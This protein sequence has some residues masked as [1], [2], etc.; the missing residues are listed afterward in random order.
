MDDVDTV[1]VATIT[2]LTRNPSLVIGLTFMG[3]RWEV[4]AVEDLDVW[5]EADLVVVDVGSTTEGL[6]RIRSLP[7]RTGSTGTALVIGDEDAA[8]SE[9]EH[10]LLR[11]FTV[12]ELTGYI[13]VLL[14][15]EPVP[16]ARPSDGGEPLHE[17]AV[18]V[19]GDRPKGPFPQE[20]E[21]LGARTT[22]R[23]WLDRLGS[24][25]ADRSAGAEEAVWTA[26]PPRDAVFGDTDQY[27]H[28]EGA[29]T[30]G[31][32]DLVIDLLSSEE[33]DADDGMPRDRADA[34][35]HSVDRPAGEQ[36]P[37]ADARASERQPP[38]ELRV[39]ADTPAPSGAVRRA[40]SRFTS[41]DQ[42]AHTPEA[43]MRRRLAAVITAGS[44]LESL[45]RDLPLLRSLKRVASL[46][47]EEVQE[48]LE[49]DT[50]A[51]LT[52]RA[53]GYYILASVGLSNVERRLVA[54]LDQPMLAEVDSTGGGLLIDPIDAAQAAVAGIGGAHT[55]SFMA[56]SI[57]A[58]CGRFGLLVAGRD[59]PLTEQDLD[60]LVS[61]AREAAPGIAVAQLLR[62][63]GALV[64][65]RTDEQ[66]RAE[67]VRGGDLGV[68]LTIDR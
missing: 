48:V 54:P 12:D 24:R 60:V 31:D 27:P 3:R 6:S 37:R 34:G 52:R 13:D 10:L 58:G 68:R 41:R 8:T 51:Y 66:Q 43:E 38:P 59:R 45:V 21:R 26:D 15:D 64:I 17:S 9:S 63:L 7:E 57:A 53:D 14:G 62:R 40:A 28:T 35:D 30:H 49:A 25:R 46:V 32:V 1:P 16:P 2:V 67:Q 23:G 61:L 20:G 47:V 5:P 50:A 65:D 39:A 29:P 42:E 19:A 33:A 56:A 55:E 11:P 4:M 22:L 36:E 44:E 18:E